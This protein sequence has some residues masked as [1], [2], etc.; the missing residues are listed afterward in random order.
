MTKLLSS[1]GRYSDYTDGRA[2]VQGH[3]AA[4]KSD[5]GQHITREAPTHRNQVPAVASSL[6]QKRTNSW[7]KSAA[8]EALERVW[9]LARHTADSRRRKMR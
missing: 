5:A 1:A 9:L 8:R 2:G 6:G 7:V 4:A 3:N